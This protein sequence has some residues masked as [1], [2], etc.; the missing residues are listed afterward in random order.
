MTLGTGSSRRLALLAPSPMS[1]GE[2]FTQVHVDTGRYES[3]LADLQ[4]VRGRVYLEDGAIERRQ[5]NTGKHQL[6]T[7]EGSWHILI[8][9]ERDRVS[10]C[11]RCLEH[12]RDSAFSHLSVADAALARCSQWGARFRAAVEGEMALSRRLDRSFAEVGGWALLESIRG[13][14]EALRLVLSSY[15]LAETLGGWVVI[16]TA[17]RRNGSAAILR[18][19]GGRSLEHES[20]E[21]PP[22]HDPQYRCEMEVL[23]FYSWDSN[24]RFRRWIEELK[25][26][27]RDIP[28]FTSAAASPA[29]LPSWPM[30]SAFKAHAAFA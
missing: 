13:T 12:P 26:Q 4:R 17:T 21:L 5:L 9:D 27:F 16:S 7:D 20:L 29:G 18:R 30:A 24:P 19:I 28:V 10:G 23:R 14:A 15:A 6:E 25:V 1:A 22:Y 8:L 11:M 3:L 2:F